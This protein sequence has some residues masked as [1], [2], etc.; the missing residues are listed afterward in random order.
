[1]DAANGPNAIVLFGILVA[2][3][4]AAFKYLLDVIKEQGDTIKKS[5]ETHIEMSKANTELAT[6]AL[7]LLKEKLYAGHNE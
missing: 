5:N 6:L 3:A 7:E 1:M 2:F 4:S